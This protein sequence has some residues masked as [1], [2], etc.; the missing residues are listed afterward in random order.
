MIVFD[1]EANGLPHNVT[2]IHCLVLHDTEENTTVAYNDEGGDGEPITRAITL[3]ETAD[4]LA[5]HNII[6]YDLRVISKLYPFFQPQGEII[7]TLLLSKLYHPDMLITDRKRRWP[8]MPEKLYGRH[9]LESYGY[10]LN[11]HKGDFGKDADWAV[12]SQDMQDYC[13]QDVKLTTKLCQ[14]F[15]P[16]LTG[17]K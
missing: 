12:W 1:L 5:G 6:N 10:R 9:S 15:I 7:D 3:M 8:G 17:Q 13:R 16:Y 4:R 11:E 2:T 14:H